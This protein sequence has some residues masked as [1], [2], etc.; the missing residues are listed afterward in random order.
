MHVEAKF[1]GAFWGSGQPMRLGDIVQPKGR[2]AD[3]LLDKITWRLFRWRR[4][5]REVTT[6][7]ICTS[8]PD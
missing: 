8:L 5:R 7:Y 3:D 1:V 4:H 2:P 6:T